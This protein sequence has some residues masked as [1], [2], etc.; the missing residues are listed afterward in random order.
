MPVPAPLITAGADDILGRSLASRPRRG[1]PF[2]LSSAFLAAASS[3]G[4][5]VGA[6][7][8]APLKAASLRLRHHRR[9][10]QRP[11]RVRSWAQSCMSGMNDVQ[12]FD[13]VHGIILHAEARRR[14][15]RREVEALIVEQEA[16]DALREAHE[17]RA[18][19]V[20]TLERL[21][22]KGRRLWAAMEPAMKPLP[23]L[24]G[25][26]CG[27]AVWWLCVCVPTLTICA[28]QHPHTRAL[29]CCREAPAS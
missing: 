21:G 3:L 9:G 13:F 1:A 29:N 12:V 11:R 18:R 14:R 26:F 24:P 7:A 17:A 19:L 4:T 16:Y 20:E 15:R 2:A 5:A 25:E 22:E 8:W 28:C 27:T 23:P 10:H 6:R